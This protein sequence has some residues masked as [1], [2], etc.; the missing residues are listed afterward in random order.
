MEK[1]HTTASDFRMD[2]RRFLHLSSLVGAGAATGL[3]WGCAPVA[4]G[5]TTRSPCRRSDH[6]SGSGW[7]CGRVNSRP[8]C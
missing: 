3:L 8:G 5:T 1:N 6:Q 2:R 4:P 7:A